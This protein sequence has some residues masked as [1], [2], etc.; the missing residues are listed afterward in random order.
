MQQQ[1]KIIREGFEG[2]TCYVQSRIGSADHTGTHLIL[3]TQKL[4]LAGSDTYTLI[5][6]MF[7]NDGGKTWSEPIPQTGFEQIDRI[8]C[9]F[10]PSFHQK[11]STLIGLGGSV[12]YKSLEPP[13]LDYT[14]P[15]QTFF[16]IYNKETN[17]WGKVKPP[18]DKDGN[19][20]GGFTAACCRRY[21]LKNG[22]I[23]QPV[24]RR[25]TPGGKLFAN[26]IRFAFDGNNLIWKE[27][28]N[29]LGM[30]SE[31]R[32]L[33]EPS[34]AYFNGIYYLTLRADSRGYVATSV[35]GLHFS[36]PKVWTW[37][38]GLPV[39]TYNT[40]QNWVVQKDAL[41]LVYTRKDGKNDHVFRNRAPLYLC[42]VDP[43]PLSLLHSTEIALTPERGARMGNF[44][45]TH[46]SDKTSIV[47]TTEWMQPLGC[48]KY[49]SNNAV[50]A[51]WVEEE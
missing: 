18:M 49:G 2:K 23:L 41:Y 25:L 34:I 40:Q 44:G 35:D 38:T 28:G 17:T 47:V 30:E 32:G 39:P 36:E 50:F 13:I 21:E 3:T 15:M 19:P 5:C 37:D 24:Y 48:E 26:V 42:K 9:D 4:I 22:D 27:E 1:L 10:V 11:S 45:V 31:E 16:S 33:A 43:T 51:V 46:I 29:L 12:S 14:K 8:V 7:S 6:S 20:L